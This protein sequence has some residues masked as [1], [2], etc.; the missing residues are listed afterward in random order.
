M[1]SPNNYPS[2]HDAALL[3]LI[4]QHIYSTPPQV[5]A[6]QM[7]PYVPPQEPL[8]PNSA[9]SEG[10]QNGRASV[11]EYTALKEENE[12]LRRQAEEQSVHESDRG[13]KWAIGILGTIVIAGGVGGYYYTH[14][15]PANKKG[16]SEHLTPVKPSM[17]V[18]A[19][20]STSAV[21]KPSAS[22]SVSG[23]TTPKPTPTDVPAFAIAA[24]TSFPCTEVARIQVSEEIGLGTTQKF[25]G[26]FTV[27]ENGK[28][29]TVTDNNT[30]TF[31]P[32]P[33]KGA[34][35]TVPLS[36][37]V[38][39]VVCVKDAS[40]L[41]VPDPAAPKGTFEYKVDQS[42][43]TINEDLSGVAP[44]NGLSYKRGAQNAPLVD[45]DLCTRGNTQLTAKKP[46]TPA[47]I[48]A[49][50]ETQLTSKG[51]LDWADTAH[52]PVSQIYNPIQNNVN[53]E[54]NGIVAA[55][56]AVLYGQFDDAA[57]VQQLETPVQQYISA[58]L[59]KLGK[60]WAAAQTQK[61]GG[62]VAAPNV[63][64]DQWLKTLPPQQQAYIAQNPTLGGVIASKRVAYQ[65]QHPN[66]KPS[67][68]YVDDGA[69][70]N[71]SITV[72]GTTQN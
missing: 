44:T 6:P 48:V 68:F 65:K 19:R 61:L 4:D 35:I 32:D 26:P 27:S 62:T 22:T 16:A 3:A 7:Q 53:G 25:T 70:Y 45:I 64:I 46:E 20:A 12:R 43:L 23:S 59:Q 54:A 34:D 8:V 14:Q 51:G 9:N 60:A 24:G 28:T 21:A 1:S 42:Q 56:D 71:T 30:Y 15:H 37:T 69:I 38:P 2:N 41:L 58:N 5:H 63:I 36:G 49:C 13:W 40:K 55:A 39:V 17:T 50:N 67:S 52:P 31:A 47:E 72:T 29:V 10:G 11:D 57:Y 18:S 33:A 66:D